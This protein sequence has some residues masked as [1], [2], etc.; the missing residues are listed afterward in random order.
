MTGVENVLE[1]SGGAGD[2][3]AI[4]VTGWT[5]DE[6]NS[7]LFSKGEDTVSIVSSA[8]S[9]NAIHIDYTDDG[10]EVG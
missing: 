5:Q 6:N 7:G 9:D 8:D 2:T 3:V 10:T 4:D 1:V